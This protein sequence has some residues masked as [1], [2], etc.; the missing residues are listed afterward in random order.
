MSTGHLLYAAR[1]AEREGNK[2]K[3]EEIYIRIINDFP[4]SEEAISAKKDL[5]ELNPVLANEIIAP[6]ETNLISSDEDKNEPNGN[7]SSVGAF[8]GKVFMYIVI[9]FFVYQC[10]LKP[11]FAQH[12]CNKYYGPI[13]IDQGIAQ[14]RR[15]CGACEKRFLKKW[16][17]NQNKCE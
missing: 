16:N 11:K 7:G 12:T 2:A 15:E 10:S 17:F 8:F 4:E 5:R 14:L 1:K 13:P 6:E 3:A 9:G